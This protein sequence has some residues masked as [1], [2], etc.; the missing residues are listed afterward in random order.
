MR[1]STIIVSGVLA[2]LSVSAQNTTSAVVSGTAA[3]TPAQSSQAACLSACPA[4][5]PK[6]RDACIVD[7][8]GVPNPA[9]ACIN[10]CVQGNGTAAENAAYETCQRN[11][12]LSSAVLVTATPAP[13]GTGTGT[14][15]GST[16]S[17]TGAGTG[18][19][20]S[21]S[22][23]G[24][25]PAGTSS[26]SGS[27]TGG[28]STSSGAPAATSKSAANSDSVRVGLTAAGIFGAFAAVL[29]L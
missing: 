20:D 27:A 17:A 2:A 8:T 3:L 16:A 6:C 22:S 9:I 23:G 7:P 11:C 4:T 1:F 12:R 29:A 5:D 21:S 26:G 10:A 28:S 19:T 13:T 14:K 25:K 24:V 18:A 15:S